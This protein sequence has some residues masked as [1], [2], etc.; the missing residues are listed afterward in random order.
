[1]LTLVT[2]D[3]SY[4]K[5]HT[6]VSEIRLQ[7]NCRKNKNTSTNKR[8][9]VL[10]PSGVQSWPLKKTERKKCNML[11]VLSIPKIRFSGS[12]DQKKQPCPFYSKKRE[13]EADS[14]ATLGVHELHND[15]IKK[16]FFKKMDSRGCQTYSRAAFF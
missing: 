5:N 16:I 8:M 3:L 6:Y 1:L 9:V 10:L 13:K 12:H 15:Q 2:S 4:M 14:Y 11:R 7:S